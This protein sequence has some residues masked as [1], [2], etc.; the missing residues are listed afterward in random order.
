[1]RKGWLTSGV[2]F[3]SLISLFNDASS[4]LLYPVL[5][6]Y[7]TTIGFTG[8]WIGIVE[9]I[10]EAAAGLSKGWFGK[11][12]DVRGERLPFVR[13]GYAISSLAKPLIVLFPNVFWVLFMRVS[14]RFGKGIRT[15]ARDAMLADQT[16][17][18]HRG[19]VFGFHR[20]FDTIGAFVGPLIALWYMITHRGESL[21]TLFYVAF[22]PCAV[23]ML[24]LFLLKDNTT[25][26][27]PE[28]EKPSWKA[29]FSYWKEAPTSYRKVVGG[30]LLFA[31]VNSSDLFLLMALR[32]VHAGMDNIYFGYQFSPDEISVLYYILFNLFYAAFSYPA[33]YFSDKYNPKSIFIIGLIC[34]VITYSG[35]AWMMW[36]DPIILPT[37]FP[38]VLMVVYGLYAALSEGI[39]KTWISNIVPKTEKASALGF[40]AGAGSIALLFASS[41]AGALWHFLA[42][43][44]VFAVTAVLVFVVIF[45]LIAFTQKPRKEDSA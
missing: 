19:K 11:W 27:N 6:I 38:I 20:S 4:E 36:I 12:S 8:L 30:F 26:K 28:A 10:A 21:S 13:F 41:T 18:E 37:W 35:F 15:G 43:W 17:P 1:M 34:F 44:V 25:V 2:V 3:L 31:L 40:F 32:A 33:G 42:P 24:T 22:I 29:I 16:L 39:S 14:D 45:Y 7:L 9:G 23:T 5:P